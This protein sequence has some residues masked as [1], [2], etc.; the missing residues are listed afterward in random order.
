MSKSIWKLTILLTIMLMMHGAMISTTGMMRM[1]IGITIN[2]LH[3]QPNI[4]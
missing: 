4:L 2:P 3:F 1:I